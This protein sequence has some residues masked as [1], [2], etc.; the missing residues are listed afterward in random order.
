MVASRIQAVTFALWQTLID[1][2]DQFH[3]E[4]MSRRARAIVEIAEG[5]GRRVTL[6]A[7]TGAYSD[8]AE[9]LEYS[10]YSGV[11]IDN[12]KRV[13][14][15]NDLLGLG[16]GVDQLDGLRRKLEATHSREGLTI[17]PGARDMLAAL[18]RHYRLIVVSDSWMT[19][20]LE[21]RSALASAGISPFFESMY[22]SDQTGLTKQTG[23]GFHQALRP[24][25]IN[26]NHVVHVGDLV[27]S[28]VAGAQR[29][30]V[31]GTVLVTRVNHPVSY[32][33]DRRSN[34]VPTQTVES[35]EEVVHAVHAIEQLPTS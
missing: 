14:M 12:G 31:A 8:A 4:V 21:I 6:E 5:S 2:N 33:P 16:L 23:E 32:P 28:D 29:A 35:L 18:G 13:Q 25:G 20:S 34:A 22:F 27:E 15:I 19:S 9:V 10:W 30:Q 11:A 17:V 24:T 26:P 3:S 7:A 1:E